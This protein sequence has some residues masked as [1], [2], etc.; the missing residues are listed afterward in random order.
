MQRLIRPALLALAVITTLTL[1]CSDSSGPSSKRRGMTGTWALGFSPDLD[2]TDAGR[3]TCQVTPKFTVVI[4]STAAGV[5]VSP[6]PGWTSSQLLCLSG[7]LFDLNLSDSLA[8]V[9][10]S[11]GETHGVV[12]SVGGLSST[13]LLIYAFSDIGGDSIGGT[14][15]NIDTLSL[16]TLGQSTWFATRQ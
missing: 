5:T 12:F 14:L 13:E 15:I 4:D 10:G 11:G 1:A 7:D 2:E 3:G 9:V 8:V 16:N 6:A